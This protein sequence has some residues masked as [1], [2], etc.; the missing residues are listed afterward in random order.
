MS[1]GGIN[2]DISPGGDSLYY[3]ALAGAQSWRF[4]G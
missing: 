4:K 2:R 1:F 3:E